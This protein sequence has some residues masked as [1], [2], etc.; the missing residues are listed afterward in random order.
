[1]ARRA[2]RIARVFRL[3]LVRIVAVRAADPLVVH[4]ALDE[5]SVLVHFVQNLSVGVVRRPLQEF[6][7]VIVVVVPAGRKTRVDVRAARMAGGTGLDQRFGAVLQPRQSE[8][9]FA[10]PEQRLGVGQFDMDAARPVTRFATDVDL[11]E[12]RVVGVRGDVD[13]S[14]AGSS[15]GSRRT[16]CSNAGRR[17]SSADRRRRQSLADVRRVQ[18]EPFL[19][20]RVPTDPQHLDPRDFVLRHIRR[21]VEL[22]HVLLQRIDAE[23]PLDL[24]VRHRSVRSFRV[25]PVL[26]VAAEHAGAD[27]ELLEFRVV[28]IAQNGLRRGEVHGQIVMRTLPRV[29][30]LA[31]AIDAG[32]TPDKGG[33]G[34]V[35]QTDPPIGQ[36]QPAAQDQRRRRPQQNPNPTSG[37]AGWLRYGNNGVGPLVSTGFA[38]GNKIISWQ[39]A[40]SNTRHPK[41][42][43]VRLTPTW[44]L[45]DLTPT[46]EAAN[47]TVSTSRNCVKACGSSIGIA[48]PSFGLDGRLPRPILR[49]SA[50]DQRH[51]FQQSRSKVAGSTGHAGTLPS[52][53]T[54]TTLPR[55]RPFRGIVSTPLLTSK[56]LR[57]PI[58]DKW[59]RLNPSTLASYRCRVAGGNVTVTRG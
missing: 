32:L 30:G 38:H 55:F 7:V 19:A 52:P 13:S 17:P 46:K 36:Y 2:E 29:V 16:C 24:E 8:T 22:D 12:R 4:L 40:A 31:M 28:E 5:R 50:A 11:R 33:L 47:R 25:D 39:A 45:L 14:S 35:R 9:P 42:L 26:A 49:P 43:R 59:S 44:R 21:A 48:S 10:V 34:V 27:A 54:T 20:F 56:N 57:R 3:G 51:V 6:V 37:R 23:H 53:V 41:N 15:N 58:L 18:V 1:M